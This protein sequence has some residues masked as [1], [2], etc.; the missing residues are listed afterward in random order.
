MTKIID[1]LQRHINQSTMRSLFI[2]TTISLV[3]AS[4][5]LKTNKNDASQTLSSSQS[6]ISEPSQ[7]KVAVAPPRSFL[8][9]IPL[10]SYFFAPPA[11][12]PMSTSKVSSTTSI[13]TVEPKNYPHIENLE[14]SLLIEEQSQPDTNST[15]EIKTNNLTFDADVNYFNQSTNPSANDGSD[16]EDT[17][18]TDSTLKPKIIKSKITSSLPNSPGA[19]GNDSIDFFE[20]PKSQTSEDAEEDK[21][22]TKSDSVLEISTKSYHSSDDDYE[23]V[24]MSAFEPASASEKTT[25]EQ[26]QN[27]KDDVMMDAPAKIDGQEKEEKGDQVKEEEKLKV[28]ID[29]KPGQSSAAN[30]EEPLNPKSS[31]I[32]NNSQHLEAD[33][34]KAQS[35]RQTTTSSP[36]MRPRTPPPLIA[37]VLPPQ[38]T[39]QQH[40]PTPLITPSSPSHPPPSFLTSGGSLNSFP[41]SSSASVTNTSE[42]K[43]DSSQRALP[44]K[45][46]IENIWG[47]TKTKS[48]PPPRQTFTMSQSFSS[49]KS[50]SKETFQKLVKK[51]NSM[52]RSKPRSQHDG[53][54]S[55]SN[56]RT[57]INGWD[58]ERVETTQ[59]IIPSGTN[60]HSDGNHQ[61]TPVYFEF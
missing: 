2:L 19:K 45:L 13:D 30:L 29:D 57:I 41:Q 37:E 58:A 16:G 38:L 60:S 32:V 8:L 53:V 18:S 52:S 48:N 15:T 40:L 17:Q 35:P 28:P 10:V 27:H 44:S 26:K 47:E 11:H 51:F 61:P 50:K 33:S 39:P 56:P 20:T 12:D 54:K 6:S 9:R 36:V 22:T 31:D 42:Q 43:T 49:A 55:K 23:E 14:S 34:K 25:N 59:E 4:Q 46:N 24:V 1:H 3:L 7:P 21:T 5:D